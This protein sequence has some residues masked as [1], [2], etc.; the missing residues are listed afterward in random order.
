MMTALPAVIALQSS[1]AGDGLPF[2]FYVLTLIFA[3]GIVIY[4]M[5]MK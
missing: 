1:G 2:W 4:A 3:L 5:F